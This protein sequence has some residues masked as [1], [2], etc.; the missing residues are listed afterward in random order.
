MTLQS[1][2]MIKMS[3]VNTELGRSSN[4]MVSMSKA[5][6]GQY[7][8]I[9]TNNAS[10]DRPDGS[11]P[12]A[13]SEFYGYNHSAGGGGP[14][15]GSYGN[16]NNT[17]LFSGNQGT[18]LVTVTDQD[19]SSADYAGTSVVGATGHIYV[20]YE[21]GTSFRND[22]Q[23]TEI[24]CGSD[25]FKNFSS[26]GVTGIKTTY[27]T[28]N[29]TYSHSASFLQVYSSTSPA[30]R[31]FNRNGTPPSGGT[32]VNADAIYYEG[33]N[34]GYSKDVYLRFP[35]IT[36]TSDNVTFKGYG[37]GSNMGTLYMGIYIT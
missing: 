34:G 23:V 9:N 13:L 33:S 15:V 2:G 32:G 12:H 19:F 7:A 1:S 3:E 28:T 27:R 37:Y 36:F 10:S 16:S 31:W 20:R 22:P 18:S 5:H 25:S 4:T 8:T 11:A 24:T 6:T 21:S 26:T 35:E 29:S 14:S 30:G 17:I